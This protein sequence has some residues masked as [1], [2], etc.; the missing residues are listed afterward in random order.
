MMH[1]IE[2]YSFKAERDSDNTAL[3]PLGIVGSTRSNSVSESDCHNK[4]LIDHQGGQ[5]YGQR[6]I[7]TSFAV[8][9]EQTSIAPVGPTP[10]GR[11]RFD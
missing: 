6:L 9:H 2:E 10:T 4:S 8:D 5:N 7:A 3:R 11:Y 1:V